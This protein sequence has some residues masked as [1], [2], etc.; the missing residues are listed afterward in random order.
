V[1]PRRGATAATSSASAA[2]G[3]PRRILM[4]LSQAFPSGCWGGRQETC[5]RLG[6]DRC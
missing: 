6:C 1:T 3:V 2:A 4:L 5:R